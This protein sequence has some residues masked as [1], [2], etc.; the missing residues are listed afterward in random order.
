LEYQFGFWNK[1]HRAGFWTVLRETV[2]VQLLH[3]LF[4]PFALQA[5]Q[6]GPMTVTE[7]GA[8]TCISQSNTSNHLGRLP[9]CRSTGAKEER[10]YICPP[11]REQRRREVLTMAK[12]LLSIVD[13][14]V[15]APARHNLQRE[16][17]K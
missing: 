5:L 17:H 11:Q 13:H 8:S 1:T 3:R 15:L 9:E 14:R 10:K 7:N 16:V 2:L 12:S 6:K 4:R